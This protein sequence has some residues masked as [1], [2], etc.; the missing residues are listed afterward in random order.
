MAGQGAF[1]VKHLEAMQKIEGVEV[2]SL[3]G[4]SAESTR[5]VAER[6]LESL[7]RAVQRAAG[8]REE[9]DRERARQ[10]LTR[11]A[12]AARAAGDQELADGLLRQ[13][14]TLDRRSQQAALAR[15]LAEAMPETQRAGLLRQL[16][17]LQRDGDAEGL[18]QATVDAMAEA[19]LDGSRP[20]VA[21]T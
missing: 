2:V 1:G 15:Q 10:A 9:A 3:A 14:D 6:D 12:E 4:G 7:S 13:R 21:T 8:R 5:A 16:E 11:A 19:A 20:V 18:N 17:R